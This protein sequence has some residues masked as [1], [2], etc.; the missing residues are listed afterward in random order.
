MAIVDRNTIK[1]WFKKRAKPTQTQF[2]N[3]IDSFWHKNE[4]IPIG[5]IE[6]IDEILLEKA[7]AEALQMHLENGSAHNKLF[8][9]KVDKISGKGLSEEDFTK[10]LKE[11]L[12]G[13]S[14][15]V[16]TVNNIEPDPVGNIDIPQ[17]PSNIYDTFRYVTTVLDDLSNLDTILGGFSINPRY[18]LVQTPNSNTYFVI[19]KGVFEIDLNNCKISQYKPDGGTLS[20]D[21]IGLNQALSTATYAVWDFPNVGISSAIYASN[22]LYRFNYWRKKISNTNSAPVNPDLYLKTTIT[23]EDI[24]IDNTTAI[25]LI[26]APGVGKSILVSELILAT[27][28]TTAYSLSGVDTFYFSYSGSD[29]IGI[30]YSRNLSFHYQNVTRRT[31]RVKANDIVGLLP[32]VMENTPVIFSYGGGS[33]TTGKGT[34]KFILIYQIVDI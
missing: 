28:T 10:P 8:E 18:Y 33:G 1:N 20:N 30:I 34:S 26:P 12:E 24:V 5:S 9:K 11:K 7:D 14:N 13:I 31:T 25:E 27:D 19:R 21:V 17:A 22:S 32:N 3:W 2:W 15:L 29:S 23:V 4:K 6:Q 16:K